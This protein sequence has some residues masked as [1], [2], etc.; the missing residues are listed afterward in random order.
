[1]KNIDL[2]KGLSF[3]GDTLAS[4][5]HSSPQNRPGEVCMVQTPEGYRVLRYMKAEEAFAIG[6]VA[7]IAALIDNADVDQVQAIGDKVLLGTGDFS[8]NQFG[9]SP[10][11]TFPDA[12][13]TID[14]NTGAGQTRLIKNNRR[15]T[16]Y[17][18]LLEGW[19]VALDTTSDYV[20]YSP[21]YVSLADTDDVSAIATRVRG[22]AI[23]AVTDEYWAWF[24]IKGFCPLVRGIGSTDA[25]VRGAPI[26]PSSTAGAAKGPTAAGIT[27]VE[28]A[29]MFGYAEHAYAAG[30]SAGVGIAAWLD[31][32]G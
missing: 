12:F 27:A 23:S 24:Q 20:T 11:A 26:V 16:D 17:L 29:T 18:R 32:R 21:N 4:E 9:A 10:G 14:A 3:S 15:S 7:M 1:M 22:V 6:Q 13:V 8:A 25:F 2:V 28:A 31:V 19:G 5:S 30:D